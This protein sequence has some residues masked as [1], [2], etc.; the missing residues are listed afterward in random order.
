M[1]TVFTKQEGETLGV[2]HNPWWQVCKRCKRGV[3][4]MQTAEL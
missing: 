3:T 4:A 1:K 2:Q